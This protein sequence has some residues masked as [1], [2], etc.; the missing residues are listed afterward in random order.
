MA[1]MLASF[2]SVLAAISPPCAVDG[3]LNDDPFDAPGY[4]VVC[5]ASDGNDSG[6]RRLRVTAIAIHGVA[7]IATAPSAVALDLPNSAPGH[8]RMAAL[9]GGIERA[10]G[11]RDRTDAALRERRRVATERRRAPAR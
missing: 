6:H 9:R 8:E 11:M 10:V 2:R 3:W 1:C 5:L 7:I 4:H